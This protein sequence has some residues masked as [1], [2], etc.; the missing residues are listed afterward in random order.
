MEH[1]HAAPEFFE[2]ARTIVRLERQVSIAL[3][4]RRLRLGYGA[5]STLVRQLVEDGAIWESQ[6]DNDA[7]APAYEVVAP[8]CSPFVRQVF[9]TAR[10]FREMWEEGRE[11]NTAALNLIKPAGLANRAIRRYVLHQLYR[12]QGVTLK[13]AAFELAAWA[14][15]FPG[16]PELDGEMASDLAALCRWADRSFKAVNTREEEAARCYRRM[17]CYIESRHRDGHDADTTSIIHFI[18]AAFIPVGRSKAGTAWAE[19][20]VPRALIV[21]ECRRRLAAGE[22]V[23]D[24]AAFIRPFVVIVKISKEERRYLDFEVNG[25]GWKTV[26]PDSWS[27]ET[28]GIYARLHGAG[29]RFDPPADALPAV[30]HVA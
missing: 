7:S 21:R 1:L 13:V 14:S 16:Q 19:H 10:Y 27:F 9:E 17:V 2:Q 6:M 29:I 5:A 20:V 18:P 22:A 11:G 30:A 26:M 3:I 8:P 15:T 4:Q 23:A 12:K 28:G 24:I 25:T